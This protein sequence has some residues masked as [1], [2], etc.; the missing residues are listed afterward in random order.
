MNCIIIDDDNLSRKLLEKFVEKTEF[1]QKYYSFSGAIEAINFIRK[2]AVDIDL[3]FLDI[4]MP[5]MKVV[6]FML[7]LGELPILIIVVSSNE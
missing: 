4:E 3:I 1:I 2:G 6:E 5:E 7:S